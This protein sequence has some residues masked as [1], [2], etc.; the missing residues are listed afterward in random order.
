MNLRL[1]WKIWGY[2]P[3]SFVVEWQRWHVFLELMTGSG[4]K[5]QNFP[6]VRNSCW[7]LQ[8]SWSCS[9]NCWYWM[10]RQA[11]WIRSQLLTL[12]I[13][14]EKSTRNLA[15]PSLWQNIVWRMFSR[16]QIRRWSWTRAE[17]CWWSR[18]GR[19]VKIWKNWIQ[20]TR[21]WLV[22][23]APCGFIMDWMWKRKSV[24]WLSVTGG[25]FWKRITAM[26]SAILNGRMRLFPRMHRLSCAW[27]ISASGM[28]RIC[29]MCWMG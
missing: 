25:C 13:H 18:R 15:W 19:P 23:Q 11:S 2:R 10:N 16:W 4:K 9:Q 14:C 7:T 5:P 26:K 22:C 8:L 17:S 20:I 12:S 1:G 6:E 3:R 29:R 28:R 24:R 27:R 21:C